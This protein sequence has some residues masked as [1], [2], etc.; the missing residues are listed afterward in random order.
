MRDAPNLNLAWT[1]LAAEECRRLGVRHA[2]ISPGSRSAPL[3]VAFARHG[4]I[5]V[6]VAHD[7]RGGAFMALG[8]A[9]SSG[10][11]A[12]AVM[13]SGTAVANV[14][15]A[16]VE[17][18][19]ARVPML[20]FAADRP[21]EL[22]DCGA[23]QSI[24]QAGLLDG[25]VRWSADLPCPNTEIPAEFVLSTVDE[26]YAR[27]CGIG[28]G[29]SGAVHLNWQFRE[30]LAPE[31]RAWDRAWLGSVA[32]WRRGR[33]PWRRTTAIRA[34]PVRV[35]DG[36]VVAGLGA[37]RALPASWRGTVLAD[38]SSGR[39]APGRAGA[40]LV[41]RS[42]LAH[43]PLA[44]ALAPRRITVVGGGIASKRLAEWIARQPCPTVT[45][46]A[47][48]PRNDPH[49]RAQE[50]IAGAAM[51][52]PG[53]ALASHAGW[54]RAL[55]TAERAAARALSDERALSE[56]AAIATAMEA[57]S[58]ARR[59]TVFLGSSMPVRD[60]DFLAITPP[61]GWSAAAN[62]GASGIDG[63]VSTATGH[64]V[65]TQA[66]VLAFVGD[67]SALHDLNALQ[68]ASKAES[69][70]VVVVLNNDGGGIFRYLPIAKHGDVFERLFATP[71][72]RS[73]AA[74]AKAFG[75]PSE[76]PRS[77]AALGAAVRRAMRRGGATLIEV[78]CTREASE[79][80]RTRVA[81]ASDAALR[82]AF[83]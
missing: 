16:A 62:R 12:V 5:A 66:P 82:R 29:L 43:P 30:P 48:D 46:G 78:T 9:Q 7:E 39:A 54:A 37:H 74:F 2:V 53:R 24:P 67:V 45:V 31:E 42:A 61:A 14:L 50:A 17:A 79:A 64:A 76:S 44:D 36:L 25:A 4:G 68:L 33:S 21:P 15:P 59:G 58:A 18:R 32:R 72:G 41:L 71:H 83:E 34:E 20:V 63:L 73:F 49:H 22:R 51:L 70:L 8:I 75:I 35:D 1:S 56:P 10:V 52:A 23:N 3:A 55:R 28:S 47:G 38:A 80:A 40:D 69:P 27:A 60:A 65:A 11:P 77:R 81:A 6:H 19:V 57:A 26:A 13:T